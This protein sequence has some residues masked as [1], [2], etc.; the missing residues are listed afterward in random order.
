MTWQIYL[1]LTILFWG[2]YNISYR[3]TTN[4]IDFALLLFIVGIVHA[5][6]AIPWAV[7]GYM[8]KGFILHSDSGISI[9]ILMGVFMT[10]GGIAFT[11]AFSLGIPVSVAT[12]GYSVGVILL[13]AITGIVL[14]ESLTLQWVVGMIMGIVSVYLLTIK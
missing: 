13:S 2:G 10:L 12:P 9:A 14:G 8:K 4:K 1:F 6:T 3:F 11:R 5:L 7:S